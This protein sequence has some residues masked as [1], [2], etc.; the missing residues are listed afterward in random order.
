[1]YK[2]IVFDFSNVLYEF[3]NGGVCNDMI[4]LLNCLYELNIPLY[5]FTNSR[6]FVVENIDEQ[7]HFLKYFKS[8]EYCNIYKK[9][10]EKA[11][12]KL[13]ELIG[14]KPS[15]IIL[16]DDSDI[17][18]SVAKKLGIIGIRYIDIDDLKIKLNDF[19][20]NDI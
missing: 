3:H 11:F 19:L 13:I 6:E 16:I 5:I 4:N 8:V 12:E 1:M 9:P 14:S 20:N 15:D 10:N 18:I 17:N 2:S 7:F